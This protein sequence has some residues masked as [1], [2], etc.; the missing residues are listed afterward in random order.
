[1][2]N[3]SINTLFSTRCHALCRH[4]ISLIVVA[5]IL[6]FTEVTLA[7]SGDE[8]PTVV[9]LSMSEQGTD[10]FWPTGELRIADELR[11]SD[12]T[13]I[14]TES[15]SFADL[16]ESDVRER[17]KKA[18][19]SEDGLAAIVTYKTSSENAH[20]FLYLKRAADSSELFREYDIPLSDSQEETDIAAFKVAELVQAMVDDMDEEPQPDLTSQSQPALIST[21][22]PP[23]QREPLSP[24]AKLSLAFAISGVAMVGLGAVFHWQRNDHEGKASDAGTAMWHETEMRRLPEAISL[25]DTYNTESK[26]ARAFNVATVTSYAIGGSLLVAMIGTLI[27]MEKAEE[28]NTASRAFHVQGTHFVWEF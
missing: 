27:S 8:Q 7:Q 12:M 13:V 28:T 10:V 3:N 14:S 22:P 17:L 25:E 24:R 2:Q 20:L 1:M 16:P 26:K 18:A 15:A 4:L 11:L 23:Q 19:E 21:A 9:L 5:R 6:G